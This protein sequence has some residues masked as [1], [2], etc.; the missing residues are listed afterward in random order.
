VSA[1]KKAYLALILNAILWGIALPLVKLA[2]PYTT[3]FRWLF[4]RYLFAAPLSLPFLIYFWIKA[5]PSFTQVI[6]VIGLELMGTVGVLALLYQGLKLTSAIDAAL[7]ANT[8]PIFVTLGGILFL[9]EKQEN[10]E[11][12][13]LALAVTGTTILILEP[14]TNLNHKLTASSLSG[15]SLILLQSL[16]GA[17]YLL[18]AKTH[19]QALPK[20]F[21]SSLSFCLSLVSFYFLSLTQSSAPLLQDLSTPIVLISAL[22]M[23]IFGSLFAATLYIYGQNLIEAS[24][25][26][27]FSYLQPLISVPLAIWWLKDTLNPSIILSIAIIALG[28]YLAERR[29]D[30]ITS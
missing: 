4:Y 16:I 18:L 28:V 27:L 8:I 24:E 2:L 5:K 22:Y 23:G 11:W 15:N 12:L 19:Y 6:T 17:T 3:P 25:A 1:R 20:L 29:R 9:K 14:L 7:I 10:R 21:V 26:S 30:I 13:G